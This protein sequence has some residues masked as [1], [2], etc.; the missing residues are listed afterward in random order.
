[1]KSRFTIPAAIALSFEAVLLLGFNQPHPVAARTRPPVS[2]DPIAPIPQDDAAPAASEDS[3]GSDS[4][5]TTRN[6][7]LPEPDPLPRAIAQEI[8]APRASPPGSIVTDHVVEPNFGPGDGHGFGPGL[9]PSSMLD[10]EPRARVQRPPLYP[11]EA[12]RELRKGEVIVEFGVDETG[13]VFNAHVVSSSSSLFEEPTLK[14][15]SQ[16][17]FEP[18]R[19]NG[20]PVR[21]RMMVPVEFRLDDN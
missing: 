1:M 17:T 8:Q 7:M 6:P 14:A 13:H 18:G 10:N 9:L 12:A 5:V 20:R 16:W 11:Y 15:V 2:L 4:P 19:K 21:F 3:G